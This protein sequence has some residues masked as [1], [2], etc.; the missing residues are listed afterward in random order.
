MGLAST[1]LTVAVGTSPAQSVPERPFRVV[2]GPPAE[3]ERAVSP[4]AHKLRIDGHG[5]LPDP[6]DT[7]G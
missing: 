6:L 5:G 7:V 4:A 2:P 1:Q 3:G